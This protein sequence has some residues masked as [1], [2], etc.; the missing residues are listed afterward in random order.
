M[1]IADPRNLHIPLTGEH[2][3]R[4]FDLSENIMSCAISAREAFYRGSYP[5]AL[6]HVREVR[7]ALLGLIQLAKRLSD[8]ALGHNTTEAA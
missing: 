7:L 8:H 2:A 5:L 4:A 3:E 1:R 6:H